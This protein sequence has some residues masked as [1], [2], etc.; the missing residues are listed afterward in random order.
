MPCA[1]GVGYSYSPYRIMKD[2]DPRAGMLR[3]VMGLGTSAVDRTEGS[4]PRVVNLDMPEKTSYSSSADKHRFS[5]GKAEVIDMNEQRLKRLSLDALQPD[6]PR[7][8][9]RI[10]FEH[11]Y[12]AEN[13]LYDMGIIRDV[14]FISCKGLVA[15]KALMEQMKRMLACIQEEYDYPVDTEFTINLS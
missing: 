14:K 2:S 13:R 15:N 3:L 12:D 9:D 11:D 5:Q 4:Y 6:I 1:A 7:Y 8:L 10:L